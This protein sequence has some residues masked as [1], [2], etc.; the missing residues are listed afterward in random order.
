MFPTS[1]AESPNVIIAGT[2]AVDSCPFPHL[3]N[4]NETNKN[5]ALLKWLFIVYNNG[6]SEALSWEVDLIRNMKVTQFKFA[7]K[8]EDGS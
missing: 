3:D 4:T 7:F 5:S 2:T 8:K 1:T 6:F